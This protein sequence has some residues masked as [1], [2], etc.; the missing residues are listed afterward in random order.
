MTHAPATDLAIVSEG[1]GLCP[2]PARHR[3]SL[4]RPALIA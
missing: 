1:G 2:S 3:Q 4:R